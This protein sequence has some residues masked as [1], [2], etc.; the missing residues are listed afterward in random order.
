MH[1]IIDPKFLLPQPLPGETATNFRQS[2]S[3][4][5]VHQPERLT[6]NEPASGSMRTIQP[7]ATTNRRSK[8]NADLRDTASKSDARLE[9]RFAKQ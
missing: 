8:S 4:I 6:G 3:K 1:A 9:R 5:M 2:Q 7:P